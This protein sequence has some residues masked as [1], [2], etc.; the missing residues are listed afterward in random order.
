MD[1]V[2]FLLPAYKAKFLKLAIQSILNQTYTNF[3]LII[4]DDCSPEGLENIVEQFD[5]SRIKYFKNEKNIGGINLVKQ[6]NHCLQFA[7]GDYL[8][9]AADDDLY[10]PEFLLSAMTILETYSNLDIVHSPVKIIN[11]N[12]EI[13][14][15]DGFLPEYSSKIEFVF[16]WMNATVF[17]CIGNYLFK[18]SKLKDLKFIDFP[19]AFGSDTASVIQMSDN[20]MGSIG[21]RAFNFRISSIHLS[22]NLG[23]ID[24]KLSANTQLF[25]WLKNQKYPRPQNDIEKYCF[26]EISWE[27]LYA[28]C[29]YDYYQ[30]VV[31][32]L[33]IHKL[34]LVRKCEILTAK[35]QFKLILRYFK[36]KI[37][38]K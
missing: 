27:K 12:N 20:G 36:D 30:L 33:P 38:G 32:H 9:L 8:I 37:M 22:S 2:T 10:E 25:N 15:L 18:S 34:G 11:E 3:E 4:V 28:K 13:I 6:W 5:D 16:Y 23:K 24:D 26:N 14:G 29:M 19:S 17:T 7:N 35:D 1:L 21:S 31:R